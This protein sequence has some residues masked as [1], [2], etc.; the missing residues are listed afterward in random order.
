[1][2]DFDPGL[3]EAKRALL[4]RLVVYGLLGA[5]AFEAVVRAAAIYPAEVFAKEGGPL[6]IVQHIAGLAAAAVFFAAARCSEARRSVLT[7]LALCALLSVVREADHFFDQSLGRGSYRYFASALGVCAVVVA[8]S[9]RKRIWAEI[10]SFVGTPAFFF[11]I[12][13]VFVILIYGQI[14]GQKEL[15]R[16]VMGEGYQRGVKDSVEE[17]QELL[18]YLMLLYASLEALVYERSRAFREG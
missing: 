6:E 9:A 15:W 14:V 13:A 3:R 1:M 11:G 18:G 10:L 16:A 7:L 4:L 5:L 8:V 12:F 17:I 2:A